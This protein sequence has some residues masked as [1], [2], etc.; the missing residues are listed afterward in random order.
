MGEEVFERPSY[1]Y[2]YDATYGKKKNPRF[3]RLLAMLLIL[4]GV[5]VFMVNTLFN[6]SST[7]LEEEIALTPTPTDFVFPTDTPTPTPQPT[8]S[9]SATPKVSPTKTT[10]PKTG[11]SKSALTIEV[12]NGS[13]QA[14]AASKI[15]EALKEF[16]YTIGKIGN[17]D[18]YDY[19]DVTILVKQAKS[20]YLPVLKTD[21]GGSYTI[22]STAASLSASAS[23]DAVVII[24][25]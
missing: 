8:S 11:L 3:L 1:S 20:T 12:Q 10:D 17:A 5:G 4:V 16:G 6:S 18:T 22:A 21:L 23:A 9:P 24:G 15:A 19:E 13:G 25:K 14:G 7:S 2:S